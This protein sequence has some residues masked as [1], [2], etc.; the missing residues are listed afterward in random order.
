MRIPPAYKKKEWQKL[1][2]GMAIGALIS[3]CIF[4]YIF[5]KWQEEY[6]KEN[7]EQAKKIQELIKEKAIWQADVEKLNKENQKKLTIQEIKIKIIDGEKYHLDL[8][9]LHEMTKAVEDDLKTLLAKDIE[10][11]FQSRD[12]IE[13]TIENRIHIAHDKK[14]RLEVKSIVFYTTLSITLT[15]RLE[16]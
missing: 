13:Q 11:A 16:V 10:Y 3:W 8:Y 1:F 2:S 5:G 7:K 12:L 4:L 14:Y 9:T 6:S 15:I